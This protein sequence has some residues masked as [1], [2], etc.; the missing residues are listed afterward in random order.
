MAATFEVTCFERFECEVL[1]IGTFDFS[2]ESI[3]VGTLLEEMVVTAV[4]WVNESARTA[5][6]EVEFA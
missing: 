6:V 5:E 4:R 1:E 2:V 3:A